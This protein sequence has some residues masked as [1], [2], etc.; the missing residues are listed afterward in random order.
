VLE[1]Q[2]GRE[3]AR[4]REGRETQHDPELC[5]AE[6][7]AR[8]TPTTPPQ[9]VHPRLETSAL[10][11]DGALE[12]YPPS[13]KGEDL[14]IVERHASLDIRILS[15]V[16]K[17]TG[18]KR[19]GHTLEWPPALRISEMDISIELEDEADPHMLVVKQP[20]SMS[21]TV[22]KI[23]LRSQATASG[24]TRW[25]FICGLSGKPCELLYLRNGFFASSQA[26]RLV[27]QSQR[28]LPRRR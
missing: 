13:L 17:K 19:W 23:R 9:S 2:K 6:A 15:K 10:Y 25:F 3:K 12:P 28:A 14:G 7:L 4:K 1:K 5:T 11:I 20:K 18:Q 21:K 27:H 24:G 16:W 22:Q 8:G 26:Q